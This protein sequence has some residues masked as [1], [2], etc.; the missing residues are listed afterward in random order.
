MTMQI[1]I[2]ASD[3]IILA[4]DTLANRSPLPIINVRLIRQTFGTSKI[5]VSADKK[6]AITCARDM[7]EAYKLADA[8]IAGLPPELWATPDQRML[9]IVWSELNQH[10]QWRGIECLVAF[11]E[12]HP[13]LYLLQCVKAE[14]GEQDSVCHRITT[15]AFAGDS[16][17]QSTYW[18]MRYLDSLSPELNRVDTLVPLAAQIVVEAKNFNNATVSGLEIVICDTAGVRRFT[19]KENLEQHENAVRR[20][21]EIKTILFPS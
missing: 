11:V 6:I 16:S 12:P 7:M 17:N 14:Q 18:A 10:Q 2:L 13:A 4:S 15:Y 8:I 1:G 20:S 5:R 21:K 3:G 19:E 9:E